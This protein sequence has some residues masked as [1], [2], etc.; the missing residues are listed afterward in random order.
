MGSFYNFSRLYKLLTACTVLHIQFVFVSATRRR[1]GIKIKI[2]LCLP[3]PVRKKL[4]IVSNVHGRT[5]KC[6]F[7]V[8]GRK[9]QKF[10]IISLS[11]NLVARLI[12]ICR[13]QRWS[14]FF[15]A[16][17]WKC[18][19]WTNLVNK[20]K[21]VTLNWNLVPRITRICRI[22]WHCSLFLFQ[23]RN[24]FFRLIWSKK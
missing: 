11:W 3:A 6:D 10:K 19:I 4:N 12:R 8:F 9:F 13:T 7:S 17:D 18:P 14:S 23:T 1:R 24:T 20:V 22:Q 2:L 5:Y 16:L 21:I 15:S